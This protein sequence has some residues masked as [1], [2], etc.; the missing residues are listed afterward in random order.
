VSK[1]S[2]TDAAVH[3]ALALAGHYFPRYDED[4]DLLAPFDQ[5]A[6]FLTGQYQAWDSWRKLEHCDRQRIVAVLN[7]APS[8]LAEPRP[9][10]RF[11][12][13]LLGAQGTD[14]QPR[15]F[16]LAG[17]RPARASAAYPRVGGDLL[18]YVDRMLVQ[19]GRDY[20]RSGPAPFAGPGAWAVGDYYVSGAGTVHAKVRIPP[21]PGFTE[22][23]GGDRLPFLDTAEYADS[24]DVPTG[25]LLTL[26]R[27][28][29]GQYAPAKRYLYTTLKVLF[30]QL[31]TTDSVD[32]SHLLRLLAGPVEIF[33][34]PTGTGKSVLVRVMASWYA[35]HRMRLAVVL[36]SA[37]AT[38]KACWEIAGDLVHLGIDQTC[39][40]LMSVAGLHDRAM[41][42]AG[43]IEEDP[44]APGVWDGMAGW[45]LDFFSYGCSL[46]E[47]T[48]A[49]H[50]FAAG[51]E[52]C[53]SLR[54]PASPYGSRACPWIPVCGKFD[55]Y[56]RASAAAIVVTNHHNF[57]VGRMSTGVTVDGRA[58]RGVSVAEFMLRGFHT[59][60]VDEVDQFQ[61]NAV[62]MC[63]SDLKLASRRTRET[64]LL[65]LEADL[66]G[67]DTTTVK[68][69][70]NTVKHARY[71][72]DTLLINVCTG[73]LRLNGSK[74][75]RPGATSTGWHLSGHNDRRLIRL[76]FPADAVADS[77][78]IPPEVYERFDAL[79]PSAPVAY[80][81]DAPSAPALEPYLAALRTILGGLIHNPGE[82]LLNQAM[83]DMA[84][85]LDDIVKDPHERMETVNLLIVRTL[86]AELDDTINTLRGK[87]A[88]LRALNLP[89]AHDLARQLESGVCSA[90]PY[91]TLGRAIT[92]YRITGLDEP[93][94]NAELTSQSIAG[95]PHT[96]T[97]QLGSV[98][99]LSLAGVERPVMGLSATAYFPQAVREHIHS[100][101]KW[102]M[103]DAKPDSI[104]AKKHRLEYSDAHPMFGEAIQISGLPQK[105][106]RHA[107]IEMGEQLYESKIHPE[108]Q[109]LLRNDPDR[110]HVAVVANS[111]EHCNHLAQGIA[112]SAHYDG[113]LCVAVPPDPRKRESLAPLP[114]GV[115]E[116]VPDE[117][118]AF[119][120]K[121]RIIV[122]PMARIARGLNIVI[123]TKSAITSVYLCVRPLALVGEPAEMYA[124]INVAG[125]TSLPAGGSPDPAA[126]LAAARTAAW[127]RLALL[128]RSAPTFTNMDKVLQEEIVAGMIVDLIQLAGRA[129]RG[130]TDMGLHLVDYAFHDDSWNSAISTILRR[131][132]SR[133]TPHIRARMDSI[134][135]EALNAFL[136]YASITADND[137]TQ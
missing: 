6:F 7:L 45:K 101:V 42:A 76:L 24:L 85:A 82:D 131:M 109:R 137:T 111:Y 95:D 119:P 28:L 134:Y 72:A 32:P 30:G 37:E 8:E 78:A 122:V 110:A 93:D 14:E 35:D 22:E 73:D 51:D 117:F 120:T 33:N 100:S 50:P 13:R 5:A 81:P 3:M 18:G 2:K 41:K 130:G 135:R 88:H 107:L 103:T 77:D 38:L 4:G 70:Q 26:A 114:R 128:Q 12:R 123:G 36:P 57:M 80:D 108:L 127:E 46:R 99:A 43:R 133:W 11:A 94:K 53:V 69:I 118:E 44:D 98:V 87:T 48:E 15:P 63:A 65:R 115:V 16:L 10:A 75:Q 1:I 60:V 83:L 124:S 56:Y 29:D 116:L 27:R 90:L 84:E 68:E 91:G 92:G 23:P 79:R 39:A 49:A 58:T 97:A 89:S 59:L 113:G 54:P 129:R 136:A 31:N 40:P 67:L 132:H 19:M 74:S 34:A 121:G 20:K 64:P 71:L 21:S 47:Y 66:H 52:P 112:R 106:K 55:Q 126:A 125:L 61:S 105:L 62:D 102:W 86:L 96:Y 25:D 9:F 104:R 17:D